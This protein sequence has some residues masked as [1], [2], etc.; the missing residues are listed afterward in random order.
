MTS[1]KGWECTIYMG[2]DTTTKVGKSQSMDFSIDRSTD[3]YY[4]IGSQNAVCTVQGPEEISGSMD[5]M[6]GDSRLWDGIKSGEYYNI[7]ASLTT[8]TVISLKGV[9]FES[10]SLDLP[11]DDF[12]EESVDFTAT[13][14]TN[15]SGGQ[16]LKATSSSDETD[17]ASQE[18]K[19]IYECDQ[20]DFTSDSKRGLE[21]HKSV[22]HD[23]GEVD[24]DEL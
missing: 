9:K 16:A 5:R 8:G 24:T 15:S 21:V 20:C 1:Y 18:D 14:V 22:A 13:A 17:V 6:Y 3:K 19:E 4:E 11:Q 12:L 23:E 7:N 10:Y 2:T